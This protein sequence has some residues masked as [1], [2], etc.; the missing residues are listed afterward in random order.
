MSEYNLTTNVFADVSG[1]EL[2]KHMLQ[3][4]YIDCYFLLLEIF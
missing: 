2:D 1:T 3:V 4:C